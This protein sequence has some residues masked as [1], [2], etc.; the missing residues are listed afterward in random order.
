VNK[1]DDKLQLKR[2]GI[3]TFE[4][5]FKCLYLKSYFRHVFDG[6]APAQLPY[7]HHTTNS[8]PDIQLCYK[9]IKTGKSEI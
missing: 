2:N 7:K 4:V 6:F 9:G 5:R 1:K 8:H 3:S